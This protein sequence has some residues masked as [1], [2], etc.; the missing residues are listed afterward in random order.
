MKA[1]AKFLL[2]NIALCVCVLTCW[3]ILLLQLC[4]GCVTLAMTLADTYSSTSTS[5]TRQLFNGMAPWR[6]TGLKDEVESGAHYVTDWHPHSLSD[7]P[8]PDSETLLAY[9]CSTINLSASCF[10]TQNQ[11]RQMQLN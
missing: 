7:A 6:G 9:I 10:C 4:F 8:T 5:I 2:R 11:A 1:K 3:V